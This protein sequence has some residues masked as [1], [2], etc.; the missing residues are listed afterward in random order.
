MENVAL[1]EEITTTKRVTTSSKEHRVKEIGPHS[2]SYTP[3]HATNWHALQSWTL[4]RFTVTYVSLTTLKRS[5]IAMPTSTGL[6][7]MKTWIDW[8][9]WTFTNFILKFLNFTT[10]ALSDWA[11]LRQ[12]TGLPVYWTSPKTSELFP[13]AKVWDQRTR[14]RTEHTERFDLAP[15]SST[16]KF[17]YPG[18]SIKAIGQKVDW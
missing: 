8:P 5:A 10:M 2:S 11:L 3:R 12:E 7:P 17:Q 1:R 13:F 14:W 18:W 15:S 4:L 16:T 6:F 9:V